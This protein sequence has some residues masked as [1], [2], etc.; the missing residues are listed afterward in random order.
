MFNTSKDIL[1]LSIA[2]AVIIL[3]FFTARFLFYLIQN[4]RR[5]KNIG[6][7]IEEAVNKTNELIDLIKNRFK[8]SSSHLLLLVNLIEKAL[9]YFKDKKKSKKSNQGTSKK[10]LKK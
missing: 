7:G 4:L 9:E 6:D 1:N 3:T 2:L 10:K 8:S 5:L